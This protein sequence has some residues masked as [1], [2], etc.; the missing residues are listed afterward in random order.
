MKVPEGFTVELVA[1]EPDLVNPVTMCFDERGRIW[2]AESLEYPRQSAGP[3]RDRIK[4]LEDTDGDGKADRFTV[5]AEGLNI[6]SGVAV[7]HGG[8]WV[9]NSPDI[10]FLRDTDGDG[11]A[12]H[13]EVVVT[14]FGRDDTHELPNSLCWGP[15]GWL[16]G[17]NGV[18]NPSRIEHRGKVHEFTCAVFRIHPKTRDF[19]VFCEGTSNPWGITWDDVGSAFASACVID[20]L[21]H[22]VETGYY[23]RQGGP[24]PP[25]T[26]PIGSIVDHRHQQAAYCGIHYYDSDTYPAEYRGRLFMGNIHGNRVN[27]DRLRRNGST[28]VA[29]AESDFLIADDAWFMPVC[30]KTGPDGNLYVLDWYDRYHCYQDAKRDS[31]GVDRLKGRLYRVRY[32]DTP[33]RVGFNL[34]AKS[35]DQ[36]V[37]LLVSPN[38]FDRETARRLLAER[39]STRPNARLERMALDAGSPRP[40]R[41]NALWTLVSRTTPSPEFLLKL[42]DAEDSAIRAWGVRAAANARTADPSVL[43]RITRLARDASPDVQLQVAVAA[44]KLDG[45]DRVGVLTEVVSACGADPLIPHVVWQNLHPALADPGRASRFLRLLDARR[46]AGAPGLVALAPRVVGRVVVKGQ[47]TPPPVATLVE[48]LQGVGTPEAAGSAVEALGVLT[49]KVQAGEVSPNALDSLQGQFQP[50]LPR[51]LAADAP[52][53]LRLASALL[54]ATWGEPAAID[55]VRSLVNDAKTD[56]PTRLTALGSLIAARDGQVFDLVKQVLSRRGEPVSFRGQ[57]LSALSRLP[58]NRVGAMV[59]QL[60]PELEPELRPRAVEL[61]TQRAGW[62]QMLLNAL[63]Q[64]VIPQGEINLNQVRRLQAIKDPDI[65]KQVRVRWGIVREGRKPERDKVIRRIREALRESPG[66]PKAGAAVF[67]KICAQCHKI[68]GEGQDVGPDIT[69]NGRGS[70][71]QLLSNVLDPNLVIG[72]AYQGTTVATAD[73][74][75]LTGLVAERSAERIVLKTQGGKLETVAADQV[76]DVK[77]SEISLMPEDLETQM[78]PAELAD[79]FAYLGLDRPPDDPKAKPIPGA[80]AP[81]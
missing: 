64:G 29:S 51:S 69:L 46:L 11:K 6:P 14:G 1:S 35:D 10:L 55:L 27:S 72:A 39:D 71:D 34:A 20:H 45:L 2:V 28:Y 67:K 15:D 30:Q 7:G 25:F 9:A 32:R 17:W 54:A 44:G 74:R 80:P 52:P 60:Y 50:G 24:Y 62:G 70:F 56:E 41:L 65:A 78:S 3:G 36:L 22:L 57:I 26:W 5:F 68:Y 81:R 75:V 21:W 18:F 43:D 19:E 12:D 33:R 13:R 40:T 73:G 76:E 38:A 53:R 16:Y 49:A 4:V 58:D 8:V 42:L 47:A 31:P 66:D 37:D 61:L 63:D 77:V 48:T 79:L 23:H 59:V